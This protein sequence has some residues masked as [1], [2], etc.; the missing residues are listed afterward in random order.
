MNKLGFGFLRLPQKDVD[1]KKVIDYETLNKLVDRFLELG[2]KYFDTAYTYLDGESEVAL[3]ESLVKRYPRNSYLIADKL[4]TW[5]I[6]SYD[7]CEKYFQEQLERC[8]VER[9]DYYLLH[10]LNDEIYEIAVK[11]DEF[12]FLQTVKE[13]GL[14]DYIGFSYH[15]SS[16]LLDRI[17]TENP[18]ID[19]V[20]LQI[21][22]LDWLSPTIES[23][24]CCKICEKH[25]KRV[26]VMEPVKG[27]TLASLPPEAEK[28]LKAIHPESSIPSWAIRFAQS[29]D[30]VDIVLSGMNAM[31]QIEDNLRDVQPLT[32]DEY[33]ALQQVSEIIESKTAVACT[34]CSYCTAGCPMNIA[35]PQYFKIYNELYR[36]PEESWKMKS[37]YDVIASKFGIP[38]DCIECGSCESHCPQKL[39][40]IS[41]LKSAV[42]AFSK[43]S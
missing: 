23:A 13:R 19:Y 34:G 18:K 22:Y 32:A 21:N 6:K 9:F 33:N 29:V 28:V 30:C 41:T 17:L 1:D 20:Q 4:P 38:N 35:I 7:D 3:R 43:L 40:I 8:G 24:E 27:G 26:I 42:E 31:A 2:G 10:W 11:Y 36:Y 12:K 39:P 15:G 16:A 5:M 14:A 37:S 25:G